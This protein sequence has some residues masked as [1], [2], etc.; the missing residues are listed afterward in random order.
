MSIH[1]THSDPENDDVTISV[2]GV[3]RRWNPGFDF[4]LTWYLSGPMSGYENFNYPY[5]TQVASVL[6]RTGVTIQSPHEN[7][8]PHDRRNMSPEAL[9]EYMMELC[10]A[11]MDL[12]GGI[13]LLRGWPQ[14]RGARAE[15]EIA[16]QRNWPVWYYHDYQLTNMNRDTVQPEPRLPDPG[17]GKEV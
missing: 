15:L 13:I 7:A 4:D 6:R 3:Q 5:F 14:S 9:W 16:L 11:Q 12:C 10:Y 2:A 17:R 1:W 8:M